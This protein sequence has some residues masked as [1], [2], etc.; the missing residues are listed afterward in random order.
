[1]MSGADTIFPDSLISSYES[2]DHLRFPSLPARE[3]DSISCEK[4]ISSGPGMISFSRRVSVLHSSPFERPTFSLE[5]PRR[6]CLTFSRIHFLPASDIRSEYLEDEGLGD[7]DL[8]PIQSSA[9]N[10][11]RYPRGGFGHRA[12][13]REQSTPYSRRILTSVMIPGKI[14]I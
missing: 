2:N 7:R 5:F 1:M 3:D 9:R 6:S 12:K 10:T 4:E 14:A 11:S 13:G 8:D